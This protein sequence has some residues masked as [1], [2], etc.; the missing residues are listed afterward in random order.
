MHCNKWDSHSPSI[1]SSVRVVRMSPVTE[2]NLPN[3]GRGWAA[4][5]SRIAV[6]LKNARSVVFR[7]NLRTV[8]DRVSVEENVSEMPKP[9]LQDHISFMFIKTE[10]HKAWGLG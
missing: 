6:S 3:S 5:V 4:K 1:Y 7:A 10:Q 9:V 2:I 8:H